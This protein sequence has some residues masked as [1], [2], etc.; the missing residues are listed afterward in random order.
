FHHTL[1]T[2]DYQIFLKFVAAINIANSTSTND[3]DVYIVQQLLDQL[4]EEFE[5]LYTQRHMSSNVHS[6]Q[7]METVKGKPVFEH[8][9]YLYIV[10][11]E[12]GQ[13]VIWCCRN[14][15][16]GQCHGRLHT[17]NGQVVQTVG[18]H[19]HEP[20]DSAGEVIKARTKM[21]DASKQTG[22]TTHDI[23]ADGVSKLSDHAI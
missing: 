1:P 23:V 14:Y 8:Q 17:I 9:G 21:S 13:K 18:D 11:K 7:H 16:H 4:V 12:S 10:S 19:N 2:T 3:T 15:R 6:I 22:R 5:H 20:S